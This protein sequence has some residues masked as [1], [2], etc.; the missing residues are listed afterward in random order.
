MK[1]RIP[2]LLL[3]VLCLQL[4]CI[5]AFAQSMLYW[6]G[7]GSGTVDGGTGTW[8]ATLERWSTT[9]NGSTYQ[10]W[11]NT[12][13]TDDA[14][15]QNTAGTVTLGSDITVRSLTFGTTGYSLDGIGT[16]TFDGGPSGVSGG[17]GSIDTGSGDQG[18]SA[19]IAGSDGLT[20]FGTGTLTLSGANT[21]T[22]GFYGGTTVR[23]GTLTL[24]SG[25]SISTPAAQTVVGNANGDDGTFQ[26]SGGTLSNADARIGN[27]T[28]SQGSA[29]VTSGTWTNSGAL[30]IGYSGT[31]SL[32]I[33]GGDVTSAS[34]VLGYTSGT[35]IGSATV[36]SG[37]WTNSGELVVG[38]AG[39]G[40]LTVS[41]GLVTVEAVTRTGSF[42]GS[43]GS[44]TLSG[45]TGNRGTLSTH[46]I[47]EAAAGAGTVTFD[48]G[49]LQARVA[50]SDFISGYE[51][52]DVIINSG[53]AFLDSNGFAIGISTELS[54]DGGLTKQGAGTLTLSGT[55]TYNGGTTV[56]AGTLQIGA[57]G[58]AGS[59]TG[60]ILDNSSV[61]FNRSD[62]ITYADA[63]SGSGSVTKQSVGTLTLSGANTYTGE[64][65]VSAGTLAVTSTGGIAHP[66]GTLTVGKAD[67]DNGTLEIAAGGS[68]SNGAGILGD[69]AGSTGTA[70]ISGTWINTGYL[71]IGNLGY[72]S[73]I[74]RAGGLVSNGTGRMGGNGAGVGS[75]VDISGTWTNS[76]NIA[77]GLTTG[78]SLTVQEGGVV[79]V[80]SGS[81][82]IFFGS[83]I[84][85]VHN[86]RISTI[87][88]MGSSAAGILNA[89]EI[90]GNGRA[91]FLSFDH[92]DSDYHF[93]TDGAATGTA[94]A[95]TG[96]TIVNHIGAGTTTLSGANTY[97][98]TTTISAGTLAQGATA[99]F[100]SN[101]AYVVN[102]GTL[103]LNDFNLTASSFSGAGGSVDLGTARLTLDLSSNT[104]YAG[105]ILG[106]GELSKAGAGSLYL[107]G[108][109]TYTGAT[110]ISAGTLQFTQQSALYNNTP[111]S[112]THTNLTVVSGATLALNV[113]GTGEFTALNLDTLKAL[114]NGSGGFQAGS[115]LGLDTTNAS[116][117]IFAYNSDITDTNG[118]ADALGL[119]KL[120][121]GTLTL[122][123]SNTYTGGTTVIAGTLLQE[124]SAAFA[125]NTAYV[126]NGGTLDLNDFDLTAS[127]LSGAGG[128]VD[129]GTAS[130]TVDQSSTTTYSGAILGTGGSVI[131][132]GVGTLTLAGSNTYTGGT[133]VNGG[134]IAFA[135]GAKLGT[136]AITLDGGG[137]QWASGNTL[138]ISNRLNPLGAAGGTFDTNGNNVTLATAISGT[139][140]S[141][142][143]NGEGT[144]TLSGANT[145]TGGTTLSAGTLAIGNS[146]ALGSSGIISWEGGTLQFS[147]SNTIDYS[148]RFSTAASQAYTFDT[149]GQDVT[150]AT[151]LTSSGGT[152]DKS[153]VG[154][155]TLSGA[156]TYDGGTTLAAGTLR[157]GSNAAFASNTAYTV[158]GGTL[159]LNDFALTASSLSGS[160]GS[161]D[162]GSASLTVDQAGDGTYAG[163]T[164]GTGGLTKAGTGSLTLSNTNTYSGGTTISE[165]TLVLGH[166]TNTLRNDGAV[167]ISA[168]TLA[169]GTNSDT[170]GAVSMSSGSITGSGNLTGSSYSFTDSGSVSVGLVGNGALIK[171]GAGTLTLSGT[172]TYNGRTTV[173]GG[174]LAVSGI[175]FI[176]PS[177]FLNSNSFT[178]GELDGDNGTLVIDAG[179]SI[180][181]IGNVHLG[182][183]SGSTGTANISGTLTTKGDSYI[184][185]EGSGSL[186]VQA[187]GIFSTRT[188]Y[189]NDNYGVS[190]TADIAGVWTMSDELYIGAAGNASLTV[191]DSGSVSN[192]IGVIGAFNGTSTA[193]ISGTWINSDSLSVGQFSNGS[194][195]IHD[196]GTVQVN[197][198]AGITTLAEHGNST[199]TLNI[200]GSTVAGILNA[201]SVNGGGGTATLNFYQSA[202]DYHFT[203]DGAATGTDVAITGSISVNHLGTGTTTLSGANTYTGDTTVEAG[204]LAL[205][206]NDAVGTGEVNVNGG[207]FLIREGFA[208]TNA[209]TLAGGTLAREFG[210]GDSLINGLAATSGFVGGTDTTV[211]LLGGTASASTTLSGSFAV[212]SGATNDAIRLSD[213]F[214][215]SGVPVVDLL[216]GETDLFTLQLQIDTLSSGRILGW[217]DPLSNTWVNATDGN[218]GGTSV[219]QGD[220]A[221]D[222]GSDFVLGYYGVDT[223]SN[224]AWAVL[225]HNSDFGIVT[226]VPEPAAWGL[227]MFG[228]VVVVLVRR[229]RQ[230]LVR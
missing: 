166:A 168:G 18:I 46:Q 133:T 63:I 210:T 160:G 110:T 74:V 67:G 118:G 51:S 96:S 59:V 91:A 5:S 128:S 62:D 189:M 124:A 78:N 1:T 20:K 81:G 140:G 14:V 138:D 224:S 50:E 218:F 194:L 30:Q 15:F 209:I 75:T 122:G 86:P 177:S 109:N 159:D 60:N 131:K 208:P 137:L 6:D 206:H 58:T 125:T 64:T 195:T 197:A 204:T 139:G 132:Q 105:A 10:T 77:M 216:T 163:M 172:N 7:D 161:V 34:T 108:T 66:S 221:Y 123:G 80:N 142:T 217:R 152:L 182:L 119:V 93:T 156:N 8:D 65:T 151:A 85:S 100:S 170:V 21:Y 134:L 230:R 84:T 71:T 207:T 112:W 3:A 228:L 149:N 183:T 72:G 222:P 13:P 29:T 104:T 193:D 199:G 82:S 176:S 223:A 47:A 213:A 89:A 178:V 17:R 186:I 203:T 27:D 192:T 70:D 200:T 31:G 102:G 157:Q 130:L 43:T 126:V 45:T 79:N 19:T 115:L 190:S 148:S 23:S 40:S 227:L 219:F 205:A 103:D 135:S 95:I 83:L 114:G 214:S 174:T 35:G 129:L 106:T 61:V 55:N 113:G 49:I 164:L 121:T 26:L 48:G 57:G 73:L 154:T 22:G 36:S 68:V 220:R 153:G 169:L 196:G 41:G 215:L 76:G 120:G 32:L 146:D 11:D 117:G 167:T 147:A 2:T 198:G 184:G 56:E 24:A 116:G 98:G 87:S 188:A 162:L 127:S 181:D 158:N 12:S 111:A 37:L 107:S 54:G 202:T 53:G 92:T 38:R 229:R 212:T 39:A 16:L 180:I 88:I 44:I 99:A 201:A 173:N 94:I 145:Y 97:S 171:T 42:A 165:G 225:N 69:G 191:Q 175:G 4:P 33:D 143:K 9:P 90:Q 136:G 52:G 155:L 141:L 187:G 25:G 101:T 211:S 185:E 28:G 226:A 150:L 144:L 179:G